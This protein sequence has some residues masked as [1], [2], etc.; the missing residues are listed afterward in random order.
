VP[1]QLDPR[2]PKY[3][4]DL[5]DK[6]QD[7]EA[8]RNI[9]RKDFELRRDPS[10]GSLADALGDAELSLAAMR[11]TWKGPSPRYGK[12]WLLFLAPYSGMRS[13]PGYKD[14]MREVGLVD[15]WQKTGDW[16]DICRP[17]GKD[18]FECH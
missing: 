15:Y 16:G 8:M 13:L 14:L 6:L 17:V 4:R 5:V 10:I 11:A 1:K 18:D 2:T 7:R 12:Y 9:L 3:F